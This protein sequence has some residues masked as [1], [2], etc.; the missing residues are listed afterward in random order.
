MSKGYLFDLQLF[1]DDRVPKRTEEPEGPEE[2]E[3]IEYEEDEDSGVDDSADAG[4]EEEE[5]DDEEEEKVDPKAFAKKLK[6]DRQKLK[7]EVLQELKEEGIVPKDIKSTPE[8][9]QQPQPQQ[10][11]PSVSREQIDRIAD[12]LSITP[13]LARVLVDQQTALDQQSSYIR[14]LEGQLQDVDENSTK[15]EVK[16]GI[17]EERKEKPYLP[18]WNEKE[19]SKIRK[20]YRDNHGGTLSWRDAYEKYVAKETMSGNLPSNLT[21]KAEQDTLKNV[22]RRKGSSIKS[23]GTKKKAKKP[24]Y[25]DMSQE[26][27]ERHIKEAKSGK[28][29][30][31]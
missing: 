21:R 23:S 4:Q 11:R 15:G 29:T 26:E 16:L 13:E 14:R 2:D 12:Q 3:E 1:A 24:S 9:Q 19:I 25:A 7:D 10:R 20:E 27:F 22:K 28:F 31:S 5:G 6:K 17:E 8:T 30:K 18:E